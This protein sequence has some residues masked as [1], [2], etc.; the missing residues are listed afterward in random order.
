MSSRGKRTSGPSKIGFSK[1]SIFALFDDHGPRLFGRFLEEL[2]KHRV[3]RRVRD[4]TENRHFRTAAGH[5]FERYPEPFSSGAIIEQVGENGA[6]G[7]MSRERTCGKRVGLLVER[8]TENKPP[9]PST[10]IG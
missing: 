8:R 3:H 7:K 6:F 2:S 10:E 4:V 1:T 9:S 5:V